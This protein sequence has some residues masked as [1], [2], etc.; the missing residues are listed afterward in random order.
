[1]RETAEERE[2]RNLKERGIERETKKEGERQRE[3]MT[4][5]ERGSMSKKEA[6]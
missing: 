5:R 2:R 6:K 1:M 3:I 4:E